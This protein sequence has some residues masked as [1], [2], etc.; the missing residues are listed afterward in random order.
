MRW[1]MNWIAAVW[2]VVMFGVLATGCVTERDPIDKTDPLALD[3]KLFEGEWFYKQTMVELPYSI[4]WAFVGETNETQ[5]IKWEV[6]ENYL[7]ACSIH[8]H[9]DYTDT[10][11]DRV[12]P[13]SP[14]LAY[15][16][17]MHFDRQ[18]A[19]STTTGE[20]LPILEAN[21]DKPWYQRRYF[22]IDISGSA[23][24]NFS[25]KYL[26]YNLVFSGGQPF[27]MEPLAMYD[28]MEFY[29]KA[30]EYI[31]PREYETRHLEGGDQ[32]VNVMSW[33]N[34]VIVSPVRQ[35]IWGMSW[36]DFENFIYFEN[37]RFKRRS[38][39]WRVDRTELANNGFEPMEFQDNMFRRFG[40]FVREQRAVDPI[41]GL[42]DNQHHKYANYFNMGPYTSTDEETGEEVQK[43]NRIVFYLSPEFPER[44]VTAACSI[45]ADYNHAFSRAV[46]AKT[47]PYEADEFPIQTYI[48]DNYMLTDSQS[49]AIDWPEGGLDDTKFYYINYMDDN[50]DHVAEYLR[51]CFPTEEDIE[52]AG[53][54]SMREHYFVLKR[55]ELME[56][57]YDRDGV[58][59]EG[60]P[61]MIAPEEVA[62][63][64]GMSLAKLNESLD[65]PVEYP[66][67]CKLSVE[68]RCRVDSQGNKMPRWKY[69]LGDGQHSFIYWVDSPTEYG[70]LGV[71][72]WSDNPETGQIFAGSAHIAGSVLQWSVSREMDRWSMLDTLEEYNY[73]P[74]DERYARL[75]DEVFIDPERASLPQAGEEDIMVEDD[76]Q[77]PNRKSNMPSIQ[78]T[79]RMSALVNQDIAVGNLD[80]LES[81]EGIGL[82]PLVPADKMKLEKY[83]L[84]EYRDDASLMN[85]AGTQFESMVTPASLMT[86]FTDYY[87]D[88]GEES[89]PIASPLFFLTKDGQEMMK[90]LEVNMMQSCYFQAEWLDSGY[91]EFIDKMNKQGGLSREEIR[92]AIEKIMFKGVAEHEIGHTLGLRHNFRGSA[93]ELNYVGHTGNVYHDHG[94]K[95]GYWSYK[96][97]YENAVQAEVEKFE[98]EKGY[99]PN[100]MQQF[101]L[102][103]TVSSPRNWYMYSS[104]MDY[105]DEFYFHGFGL[106]RYDLGAFKYVYGKSV[107]K[108]EIEGGKIREVNV[109]LFEERACDERDLYNATCAC[110]PPYDQGCTCIE[111]QPGLSYCYNP[112]K[113]VKAL[114]HVENKELTQNENGE[115][116]FVS[117]GEEVEIQ[118]SG[119]LRPYLFCSDQWRFEDPMC[120]VWDA[121]YTARDIARGLKDQFWRFYPYRFHRSGRMSFMEP[122][123]W[124]WVNWV[125]MRL[126]PLAHFALDLN[127]N[128]FQIPSW[129]NIIM[130]DCTNPNDSSCTVER[131]DWLRAQMGDESNLVPGG[132]GDYLIAAQEGFDFFLYDLLYNPDVGKHILLSR[133][134]DS[135]YKYFR[136]NPYIYDDA[137]LEEAGV[138]TVV[139]VSVKYGKDHKNLI[140]FQ[141]DPGIMD[142]KFMRIGFTLMKDAA[143]FALTNTGWFYTDKYG[144]ENMANGF[145]YLSDGFEN[146][147]YRMLTDV[148]NED[149]LNSFSTL[150][151]RQD[152]N[153]P[154]KYNKVKYLPPVNRSY[155]YGWT[156]EIGG[157]WQPPMYEDQ[158]IC[159]EAA[160]A[161][162]EAEGLEPGTTELIP[163]HAS[164]IYFD[165]FFPM[166]YALSNV[167]NTNADQTAYW[168]FATDVIP[169]GDHKNWEPV[170]GVNS[171]EFLNSKENKYYRA[172]RRPGDDHPSPAFQ[173]VKRARAIMDM[174]VIDPSLGHVPGNFLT[175]DSGEYCGPGYPR[176]YLERDLQ[177]MEST[178]MWM[179]SFIQMWIDIF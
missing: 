159:T 171:I 145:S 89:L 68:H 83:R 137:D 149:S 70:I 144:Y 59:P 102:S 5:I 115:Y 178:M 74:S 72:Q 170:D 147:M 109:P 173:L 31:N 12:F 49:G 45:A 91:L 64:Y 169:A 19:Q 52:S 63:I 122:G 58:N 36:G 126:F 123:T 29:D 168:Y 67:A 138:G 148:V 155:F 48:K 44:M 27:N 6:T 14:V 93:D 3:K 92:L 2:M 114:R 82:D 11:G 94:D 21:T 132:P 62:S 18:Y 172:Y 20:D 79:R 54:D 55:N 97:D 153:D 100:G 179:N 60:L 165:K 13:C 127:Y 80:N 1:K 158:P 75:L 38:Y 111:E 16:I 87:G 84:P 105:M 22:V 107:E 66:V 56:Y 124:A 154:R 99:K 61:N 4:D 69:E 30:G 57:N 26:N 39:L 81:R 73:E 129:Q 116:E 175:D 125:F 161:I 141:D 9:F 104:V 88:Y 101:W 118:L 156:E 164:W 78:V 40:Y 113:T 85:L 121:G 176:W 46:Y 119:E 108:W 25:F 142:P 117:T 152:E 120:N 112:N 174:C 150:C 136:K 139:D 163:T 71:A 133:N 110:T 162:D 130:D 8:D 28:N 34:D 143:I 160:L 76:P 146:T 50:P 131:A 77:M 98:S 15:P 17:K 47:H 51:Y 151:W 135:S 95:Q 134:E 90:N 10:N 24:S 86:A 177:T 157:A 166:L 41:N 128:R 140:D 42:T 37:Q 106:G 23:I 43:K 103:K 7:V 33:N 167:N 35:Y 96:E 65:R 32:L 53:S